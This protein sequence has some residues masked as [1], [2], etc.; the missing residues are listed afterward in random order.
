MVQIF[1]VDLSVDIYRHFR[2]IHKSKCNGRGVHWVFSRTNASASAVRPSWG[3]QLHVDPFDPFHLRK[4]PGFSQLQ[5][6]CILNI[7]RYN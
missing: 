4:W 3:A 7:K 1:L 5:S 2:N 6:G